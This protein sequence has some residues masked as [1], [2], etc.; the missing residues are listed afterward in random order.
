MSARLPAHRRPR[1][2]R[3]HE[4]IIAVRDI[5]RTPV[6]EGDNDVYIVYE[7]MDTDLHQ[8][9]RSSQQLT[10]DHYQYFVYQVR[11]SAGGCPCWTRLQ[12]GVVFQQC[13]KRA[14]K[15]RRGMCPGTAVFLRCVGCPPMP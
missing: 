10:D 3:R 9:I 7:L 4:N 1:P 6:R 11:V 2:R 12:R 14:R 5:M 13:S 8:I 15:G